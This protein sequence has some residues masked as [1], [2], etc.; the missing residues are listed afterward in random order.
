MK[1]LLT[2]ICFLFISP[3]NVAAADLNTADWY[4]YN[5]S[6]NAHGFSLLFPE[7]WQPY[8]INSELQGFAPKGNKEQPEL[9]LTVQEFNGQSYKQA[10]NN[11][12]GDGGTI[13]SVE[14]FIFSSKGE[15]L[16][17]KK[18]SYLNEGSISTH[19]FIKRGSLIISL[20]KSL[21]EKHEDTIE[22]IYESFHFSD[23]WHQYLDFKDGYTFLFPSSL[24]IQNL[25][26][27][28]NAV[29]E[30][31]SETIFS[32]KKYDKVS[33]VNEENTT[34]MEGSNGVFSISKIQPQSTYYK[35]FF[36]EMVQSFEFFKVNSRE[37][38]PYKN[39]LDV[40]DDHSN[41]KAINDLAEKTIIAGY[42]DGSFKPDGNINRAELT[43]MVVAGQIEPDPKV[44]ANCFPDVKE[45][46]FAPYI[47]YAKKKGWIEGYSN[48]K[49]KP[50]DTINH[51]EAL[52]IIMEALFNSKIVK[53]NLN[54]KP[55]E[56]EINLDAWYSK[57]YI[58]AQNRT[59]LDEKARFLPDTQISRKEVAETIY[60][61][62]KQL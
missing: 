7:D 56:K 41:A 4:I 28:V 35:Q 31:K 51:V 1:K 26:N 22:E 39:F 10:M 36:P 62:L 8:T 47:C 60:R 18:V 34:I 11:F 6:S 20:T 25:N 40:R 5:G 19:T 61:S 59:L 24:K 15:D 23:S 13:S 50:S 14:D 29:H 12:L 3:T 33:D 44:Y 38:F 46:W 17:A 2:V 55:T 54:G 45:E 48:G 58:F 42:Q 53:E 43:K 16:L 57:Y 9:L 30:S 37:Y 32:V 21:D 27:G 52:K 49:F